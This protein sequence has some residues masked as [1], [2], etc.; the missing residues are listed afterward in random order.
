MQGG[1][2]EKED[3]AAGI[4]STPL[5]ESLSTD[6][7]F[8]GALGHLLCRLIFKENASHSLTLKLDS[9]LTQIKAPS[10]EFPPDQPDILKELGLPESILPRD[11]LQPKKFDI[12]Q[13]KL[14]DNDYSEKAL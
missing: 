3:I 6:T 13:T 1:S 5:L 10:I 7:Y 11:Y 2:V 8:T 9:L 4:E 12:D 14:G